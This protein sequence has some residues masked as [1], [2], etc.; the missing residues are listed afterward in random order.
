MLKLALIGIIVAVISSPSDGKCL[1]DMQWRVLCSQCCRN[2]T[3]IARVYLKNMY[4]PDKAYT[5]TPT[6]SH[7]VISEH[8][9]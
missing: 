3:S 5:V 7:V 4:G 6:V 2:S 1:I 8:V 9:H